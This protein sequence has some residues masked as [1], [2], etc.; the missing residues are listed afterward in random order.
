MSKS[1]INKVP[2]EHIRAVNKFLSDNYI[3]TKNE[4]HRCKR[5]DLFNHFTDLNPENTITK[6][7]FF[8]VM[9][10]KCNVIKSSGNFYF[11]NIIDKDADI[12]L[13]DYEPKKNTD[14]KNTDKV[15]P[16]PLENKNKNVKSIMNIRQFR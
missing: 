6:K 5:G 10:T 15:K 4:I 8:T 11:T 12:I 3:I 2:V 1:N 16:Q 14:K 13:I 7:H 9:L